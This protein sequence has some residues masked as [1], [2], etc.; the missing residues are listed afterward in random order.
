MRRLS[1]DAR[2]ILAECERDARDQADPGADPA[3]MTEALLA[4]VYAGVPLDLPTAAEVD[5]MARALGL[6]DIPF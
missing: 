6:D 5:D 2:A 3:E 1:D 4:E